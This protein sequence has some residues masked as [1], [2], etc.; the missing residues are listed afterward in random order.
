MSV[1]KD[2]DSSSS[3]LELVNHPN[4]QEQGGLAGK[5]SRRRRRRN[6]ISLKEDLPE[7][8][9]TGNVPRELDKER[10]RSSGN[11]E[12]KSRTITRSPRKE[13][14]PLEK[15]SVEMT[16]FEQELY[17]LMGISPLVRLDKE[18]KDP[19]SVILYVKAPG[20]EDPAVEKVEEVESSENE[21]ETTVSDTPV[22]EPI[23]ESISVEE[24]V[25]P[26]LPVVEETAVEETP[27]DNTS[28]IESEEATNGRRR[29]RR[30]SSV[31]KEVPV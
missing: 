25:E 13:E 23:S 7:T 8:E 12:R 24:P 19:K 26:K 15:V 9:A 2:S 29:R 22:E 1:D 16:Q 21:S 28:T 31:Q 27:V 30:R 10:N 4:Y 14:V 5:S 11:D 18:F 6:E 3:A 20:E 17:A